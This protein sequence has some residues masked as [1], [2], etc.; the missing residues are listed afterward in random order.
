MTFE[1]NGWWNQQQAYWDPAAVAC[2]IKGAAAALAWSA[3]VCLS[4]RRFGC[5]RRLRLHAAGRLP[6]PGRCV[7]HR[8]RAGRLR[9]DLGLAVLWLL[10]HP[11]AVQ[12]L[13]RLRSADRQQPV[14]RRGLDPAPKS[15]RRS[16]RT[17][18]RATCTATRR[19]RWSLARVP[20]TPTSSSSTGPTT[21]RELERNGWNFGGSVIPENN[22]V[23][24]AA[25]S[26]AGMSEYVAQFDHWF[27]DN[28]RAGVSF[29]HFNV[30]PNTYHHGRQLDVPGLLR[31]LDQRQPGLPRH[32]PLHQLTTGSVHEDRGRAASAVAPPIF[33][34]AVI[35][36]CIAVQGNVVRAL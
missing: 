4:E 31:E 20:P 11:G 8:D 18:A 30:N 9:D 14:H 15:I 6:H 34:F 24:S 10:Q 2:S 22:T 13:V 16:S 25:A 33:F 21:V 19:T 36:R 26:A 3:P 23:F 35:P 32:V 1:F 17:R 7:P 28:F 27:N 12:R 5:A 29:L